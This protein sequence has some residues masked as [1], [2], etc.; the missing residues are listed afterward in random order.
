MTA[1]VVKLV[2]KIYKQKLPIAW[3][4]LDFIFKT[5]EDMPELGILRGRLPP[6]RGR[7]PGQPSEGTTAPQTP[8]MTSVAGSSDVA[9]LG[10]TDVPPQLVQARR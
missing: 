2:K 6:A 7:A 3:V 8:Q 9:L 10:T 1:L 5:I 4:D